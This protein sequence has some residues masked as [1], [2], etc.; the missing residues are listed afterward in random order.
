MLR[1]AIF[2]HEPQKVPIPRPKPSQPAHSVPFPTER[3]IAIT[4]ALIKR[5]GTG[6]ALWR[7]PSAPQAA[8][9]TAS[10]TTDDAASGRT[11]QDSLYKLPPAFASLPYWGVGSPL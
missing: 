4:A 9:T 6:L 7:L 11:V 5:P 1:G 10:T 3:T 2:E 8:G